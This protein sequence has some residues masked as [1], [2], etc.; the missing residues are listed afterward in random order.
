MTFLLPAG[1]THAAGSSGVTVFGTTKEGG[2]IV[3]AAPFASPP[4]GACCPLNGNSSSFGGSRL[5]RAGTGAHLHAA[6]QL[7][8]CIMRV[9]WSG[10]GSLHSSWLATLLF[11]VFVAARKAEG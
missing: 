11:F 6:R 9:M 7:S 4:Q 5:L 3:R 8:R 2:P 10:A 1:G